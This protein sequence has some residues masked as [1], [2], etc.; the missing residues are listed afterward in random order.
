MLRNITLALVIAIILYQLTTVRPL[1]EAIVRSII[2]TSIVALLYG[3]IRLV[4]KIF[5]K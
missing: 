3:F 1:D 2:L 5:G 4:S